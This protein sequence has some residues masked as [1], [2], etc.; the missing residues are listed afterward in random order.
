MRH[1]SVRI[2]LAY[3]ALTIPVSCSL[4]S[5]WAQTGQWDLLTIHQIEGQKF[6]NP[7]ISDLYLESGID[8]VGRQAPKVLELWWK[9]H[10]EIIKTMWSNS[11]SLKAGR[12]QVL[13]LNFEL[14]GHRI[15]SNPPLKSQIP[16]KVSPYYCISTVTL[17]HKSGLNMFYRITIIWANLW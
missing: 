11:D 17:R 16:A 14:W 1:W 9:G 7:D 15:N 13:P 12:V 10:Y 5:E 6:R 2:P 3:P 8:A 4:T